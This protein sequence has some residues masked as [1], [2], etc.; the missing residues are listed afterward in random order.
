MISNQEIIQNFYTAFANGDAD[1]MNQYYAKEVI[2]EDP[3]FGQLQG[4][5]ARAMWSMLHER[6]KGNL[7]I[8]FEVITVN[9]QTGQAKWIAVYP[10][11]PKKR[12][13]TNHVTASFEF[14]NGKIIKHTDH[15]NIWKWSSQALGLPGYLLGWSP[16]MKNQI[17]KQTNK[18]LGKYQ[19]K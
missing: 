1:G 5:E 2:F 10:Y 19:S 11:G 16:F 17:Q 3:A 6:S 7:Q 12:V 4:D 9:E 18:L 13:V 8:T 15:F 14:E